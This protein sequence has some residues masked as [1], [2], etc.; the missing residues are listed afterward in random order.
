[1][2]PLRWAVTSA[3][4][5][6]ANSN[7]LDTLLT[8]MVVSLLSQHPDSAGTAAGRRDLAVS[9]HGRR[10]VGADHSRNAILRPDQ[11]GSF[12]LDHTRLYERAVPPLLGHRSAPEMGYPGRSEIR[13]ALVPA[14]AN[15]VT[16]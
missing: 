4:A 12:R 6:P 7:K 15:R 9:N 11:A 8:I 16:A 10:A 2:S 3:A 1:M 14:R 13:M 5:T